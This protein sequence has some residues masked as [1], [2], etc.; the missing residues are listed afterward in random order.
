MR[1]HY[2]ASHPRLCHINFFLA[3]FPVKRVQ[4]SGF[5]PQD[6]CRL[7]GRGNVNLMLG[8]VAFKD[9]TDEL[10]KRVATYVF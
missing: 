1:K 6:A 5:T 4:H 9:E 2:S 8:R 10:S 3:P 7:Y